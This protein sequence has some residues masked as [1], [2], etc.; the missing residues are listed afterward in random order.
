MDEKNLT[1]AAGWCAPSDQVFP[2]SEIS[3]D[4]VDPFAPLPDLRARRGERWEQAAERM[5]ARRAG[6]RA[7]AL[8]AG[9]TEAALDGMEAAP[10]GAGAGHWEYA[11]RD[12]EGALTNSYRSAQ[13]AHDMY[14]LDHGDEM[15]RRWVLDPLD[16]EVVE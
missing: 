10:D 8:E 5:R 9:V 11:I 16:W 15:V 1:A 13:E 7:A 14:G 2:L 4:G 3:L 6:Q 12:N